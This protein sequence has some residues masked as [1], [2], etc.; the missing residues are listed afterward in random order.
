[1]AWPLRNYITLKQ[2]MARFPLIPNSCNFSIH[3]NVDGVQQV[4][5]VSWKLANVFCASTMNQEMSSVAKL[6]ETVFTAFF[7][8]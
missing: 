3:S 2:T 5:G 4:S 8:Q 1:M 6:S 7:V